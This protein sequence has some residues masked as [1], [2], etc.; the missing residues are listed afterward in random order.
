MSRKHEAVLAITLI[1]LAFVLVDVMRCRMAWVR[2]LAM[3]SLCGVFLLQGM[4]FVRN[5]MSTK[6]SEHEEAAQWL[7][8]NGYENGVLKQDG[9]LI[10]E[11]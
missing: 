11:I 10:T 8:E 9:I 6:P 4:V 7:A 5:Y 2:T 3:L 1:V